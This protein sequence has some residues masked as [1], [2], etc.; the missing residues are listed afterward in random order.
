MSALT[1][2]LCVLSLWN[3]IVY[4]TNDM[5][6]LPVIIMI[7]VLTVLNFFDKFLLPIS[8]LI[9]IMCALSWYGCL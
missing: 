4:E 9:F 3:E 5:L 1:L 6:R 2:I 7:L 8:I